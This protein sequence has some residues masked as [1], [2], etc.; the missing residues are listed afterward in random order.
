M[1]G[2]I[3]NSKYYILGCKTDSDWPRVHIYSVYNPAE[4]DIDLSIS[5]RKVILIG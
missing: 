1:L 2:N 5:L 4:N 3:S